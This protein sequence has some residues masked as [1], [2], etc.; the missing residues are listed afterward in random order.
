MAFWK[1]GLIPLLARLLA[2]FTGVVASCAPADLTAD[3]ILDR[4]EEERNLLAEGDLISVIQFDK[5]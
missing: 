5:R 4:V 2:V 3:E 1:L